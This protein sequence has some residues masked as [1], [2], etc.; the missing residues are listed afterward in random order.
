MVDLVKEELDEQGVP[1]GVE[2]DNKTSVDDERIAEP[3]DPENIDVSTRSMTVD[4]LLSRARSG[5]IDLQPD[6]Q[7][8]WG[9]WD[10][11]RQ[12]RLIE[13]LLLKIPLPVIYAA[14][15]ENEGWEIVDGIQR[16][17]TIS[18][19]IEPAII[20]EPPLVLSSL[21]YLHAYN[22]KVF[23]DLSDKLKMRLKETE[24]VV[25]LIKRGTPV[26]VKFNIFARINTGGV[27]LSS[28]ELRHA[29]VPGAAR[30]LLEQWSTTPEFLAATTHSVRSIR[31]DDRELVLRFI[32]F[33]SFGVAQY[34]QAD[35][36]SFLVSAM[37]AINNM[38][39][40]ETF[41]MLKA[42]K[43]SMKA[44]QTIFADDA[45]RKR[46]DIGSSRLPIN[47]A[48]F[49]AVSVSLA[50][51]ND[52][53]LGELEIKSQFVR[54][55]FMSLCSDRTFDSAISQGTG[56]IGK[57]NRRFDMMSSMLKGVVSL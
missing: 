44:A 56:D 16:L 18:R 29:I 1:T 24:L 20:S 6:F 12:S 27:R 45:F 31:M 46:Y 9:I 39:Q 2:E 3:F 38:S 35:M 43:K 15:N 50:N 19:F 36:D 53:E 11:M 21:E 8:R 14:E 25:H 52:D 26:E 33:K 13:S 55:R 23:D 51:L 48:L 22:D 28:Q 34:K 47:K 57:V 7:R 54:E 30:G 42:F 4:L 49:E 10:R 37:R 40:A 17:S 32:A 5:M 41:D